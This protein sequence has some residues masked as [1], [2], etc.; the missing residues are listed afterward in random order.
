MNKM[1]E[2]EMKIRFLLFHLILLITAVTLSAQPT[3]VAIVGNSITEGVGVGVASRDSYPAQL[4]MYLGDDFEVGNFG[5]SGRTLLKNGDFP[6]WAEPLFED[7]LNFDADILIILLGTND[8]KPQNWDDYGDEFIGDYLAMIDSFSLGDKIPEVWACLPPPAFSVQWGINDT[9]IVNE[10]I[11]AI[12]QVIA[13]RNLKSVDFYTPFI[14]HNE[15]FPDDIHPNTAGANVMAKILYEHLTG[16]TIQQVHDI[17]VVREKTVQTDS[18]ENGEALVDGDPLTAWTFTAL[19]ATAV[20]DIGEADSVDAFATDFANSAEMGIQFTIEGSVDGTDWTMLADHSERVGTEALAVTDTLPP[21]PFRYF[22]LT[23]TGAAETEEAIQISE[24]QVLAFN[25]AH[26]ANAMSVLLDR[27]SSKYNYYKIYFTPYH[28]AGERTGVFRDTGDGAGFLQMTGFKT[29]E[30]NVQYR[31]S[32]KLG[33][34]HA[35][36]II[37][38]LNGTEIISNTLYMEN[39]DTGVET[40]SPSP[41]GIELGRN[42]PNPFNPFTHIHYSLEKTSRVKITV[43]NS[44]GQVVQTI[45]DGMQTAGDHQIGFDGSGLESGVYHLM[46]KADGFLKSQKMILLK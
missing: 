19:P 28:D 10:V 36:Y 26:H 24:F 3:K 33:T 29:V 16:D 23:I 21:Q 7:A 43:L 27:E 9:V 38:Y 42:Y 25:G 17:N 34:A 6:I 1:E 5:V 31:V 37:T 4:G 22:K 11:P 44:L 40:D 14:G 45:S 20:I 39:I 30:D 32:L 41:S 12:E 8:S 46:L 35:Y 2:Y 15:Y 18:G 13:E